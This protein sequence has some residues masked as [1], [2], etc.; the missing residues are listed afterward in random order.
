VIG[1]LAPHQAGGNLAQLAIDQGD[2]L[3]PGLLV[4]VPGP[5]KHECQIPSRLCCHSTSAEKTMKASTD[6]IRRNY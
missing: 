3:T 4:T 2:H 6:I 1:T 5:P